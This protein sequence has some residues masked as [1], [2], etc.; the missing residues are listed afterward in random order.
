MCVCVCVSITIVY[1][2][3]CLLAVIVCW[4]TI[5]L[6]SHQRVNNGI[7]FVLVDFGQLL[8]RDHL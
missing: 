3:M 8:R 7:L 1:N 4:D 2:V 5:E 6:Y